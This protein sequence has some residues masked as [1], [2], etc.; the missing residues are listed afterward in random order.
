MN[1][2]LLAP[3]EINADGRARVDPDRYPARAGLW[4]PAI[5]RELRVGLQDGEI[6]SAR[7]IARDASGIEL[8]CE[9]HTPPPPPL[10][11]R[12][13]LA[14][15]RPKMLRRVLRTVAELGIKELWLV[16]AS[17]VEKSYWQSPLLAS[18]A[19]RSYLIAGLEQAIDTVM[20]RVELRHRLRPFA[21]DELPS[22]VA[23]T[24]ALVAHPGATSTLGPLAERPLTLLVGPEGG[25]TDFEIALFAAAGCRAASLGSR[26][27]RVETALPTL[28]GTLFAAGPQ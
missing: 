3:G 6:G 26:V 10:P 8:A 12:L 11:L 2:L 27:L 7:V 21:E 20:P 23:G 19:I 9:L 24:R 1:L 16:N 4:P 5:G 18:G 25:F 15:P 28:V 14:L 17:R 13:V 22:I